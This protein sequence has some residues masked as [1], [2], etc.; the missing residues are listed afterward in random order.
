MKWSLANIIV[1]ASILQT[2]ALK[3]LTKEGD[4]PACKDRM[5]GGFSNNIMRH[6]C[7]GNLS[8]FSN[9]LTDAAESCEAATTPFLQRSLA[10]KMFSHCGAW[11]IFDFEYPDKIAYHWNAE[12][13]CYDE[14]D[15]V[16]NKYPNEREVAKKHKAEL[17][18]ADLCHHFVP[19]LT[20]SLM[21]RYC[22]GGS[23]QGEDRSPSAKGCD[24]SYTGSVRKALANHMFSHCGAW[25]LFDYDDTEKVSYAWDPAGKCW[26]NTG[27]ALTMVQSGVKLQDASGLFFVFTAFVCWVS[28][29]SKFMRCG[30]PFSWQRRNIHT[31]CAI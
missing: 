6:H 24:D 18:K 7:G 30:L 4:E 19:E 27:S 15:E 9:D 14:T 28:R 11:C 29:D 26:T 25:C 10:N 12:K 16:C 8:S 23:S 17:C 13:K 5:R 2:S 3:F 21:T 20:E 31:S 1:L 22:E